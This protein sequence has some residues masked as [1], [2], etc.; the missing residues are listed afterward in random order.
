MRYR[1]T[2]PL[3]ALTAFEAVARHA[4]FSKAAQ[5]LYL[6]HSA[7][8]HRIRLLEEHLGTQLFLR[9][10]RQVVLTPRGEAF[11]AVVREALTRLHRATS[12]L[13]EHNR[14][15]LRVSVLPAFASAWLIQRLGDFYRSY[16]DIDLD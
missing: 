8:S 14:R 2:P 6:T 3:H 10:G 1:R 7:I 11:L 15:S 12:R 16:P 9:L 5:E 4:S 13:K